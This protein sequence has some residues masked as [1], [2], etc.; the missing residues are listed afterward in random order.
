MIQKRLSL[1][2]AVIVL[3]II[4]VILGFLV[5]KKFNAPLAEFE[6]FGLERIKLGDNIYLNISPNVALRNN[7]GKLT[8]QLVNQGKKTTIDFKAQIPKGITLN[9]KN[10]NYQGENFNNV[11]ELGQSSLG[12]NDQQN[13]TINLSGQPADADKLLLYFNDYQQ[14]IKLINENQ[15]GTPNLANDVNVFHLY[16]VAKTGSD[17]NDGSEKLP[18]LTISKAAQIATAGEIVYIKAGTYE[19]TIIP[20]NSGQDGKMITFTNFQND[21][22]I[23][24]AKDGYGF[25]LGYGINYIKINGLTITRAI[26]ASAVS[27][28]PKTTSVAHGAGVK[29]NASNHHLIT[30][31]TFYDNDIGVFI[32][33][34]APFGSADELVIS[35][36]NEIVNNVIYNSGEAGIRIKRSDYTTIDNNKIYHNGFTANP[37]YDE[38]AAGLTYYCAIGTTITN[39]TI[40]DNSNLALE[41]YAGTSQDDCFS[42]NSVIKN[43]VLSQTNPSPLTER[44]YGG[45][46]LVLSIA[47]Q[48]ITDSTNLYQYNTFYNGEVG[49]PLIGWGINNLG[50]QGELLTFNQFQEKTQSLNPNS[51]L[52]NQEVGTNPIK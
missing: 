33:E 30:N 31:N 14:T 25:L 11:I 48:E 41:N 10:R 45:K 12:F 46:K 21:Q 16:Y 2:S 37:V 8:L 20:A 18:F 3:I 49:S 44:I 15:N 34:G 6:D 28:Y 29:I 35:Q 36:N 13:F 47:Q 9:F 17:D 22:V 38:P 26:G 23:I 24:Q 32:S 5:L 7:Q 51:G 50:D 40:Y 39:N 43:N 4:N 42:E 19:E 1:I 27:N 52:G